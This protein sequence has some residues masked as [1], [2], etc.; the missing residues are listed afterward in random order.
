MS[1]IVLVHT[2]TRG[3]LCFKTKGLL[4]EPTKSLELET[5]PRNKGET[6]TFTNLDDISGEVPS[7]RKTLLLH[8]PWSG[9]TYRCTANQH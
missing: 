2:T 4:Y 8:L 9:A 5:M 1:N 6:K 3:T 7:M